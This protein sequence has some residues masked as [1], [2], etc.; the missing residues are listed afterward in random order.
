MNCDA[1][2]TGLWHSLVILRGLIDL[3]LFDG[4]VWIHGSGLLDR[5]GQC[6]VVIDGIAVR[7]DRDLEKQKKVWFWVRV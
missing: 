1:V 4:E 2:T 5:L 7:L 6:F 3:D